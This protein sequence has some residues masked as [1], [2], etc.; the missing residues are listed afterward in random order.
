[1]NLMKTDEKCSNIIQGTFFEK[2]ETSFF[3]KNL[4]S[5]SKPKSA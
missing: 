2:I 4:T 3:K 1:M 5:E